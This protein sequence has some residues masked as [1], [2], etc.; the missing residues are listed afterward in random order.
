MESQETDERY[1][2][3]E[4]V[5]TGLIQGVALPPNEPGAFSCINMDLHV[6]LEDGRQIVGRFML[7]DADEAERLADML[8]ESAAAWRTKMGR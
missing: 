7:S 5:V 8:R 3:I 1:H 2:R 6:T 4:K